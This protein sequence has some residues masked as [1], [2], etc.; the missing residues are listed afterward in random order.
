MLD[1]ETFTS[2]KPQQSISKFIGDAVGSS[3]NGDLASS[4]SQKILGK[5][6]SKVDYLRTRI[7]CVG[8]LRFFLDSPM[9][10]AC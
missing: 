2:Q 10:V 8:Y 4:H 1:E 7:N 5:K 6:L 9:L 3:S